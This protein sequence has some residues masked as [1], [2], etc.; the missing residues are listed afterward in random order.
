M[1]SFIISSGNSTSA[2]VPGNKIPFFII[3]NATELEVYA[4]AT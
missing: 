3:C 1:A 2:K 4:V